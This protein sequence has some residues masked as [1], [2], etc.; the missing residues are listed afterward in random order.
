VALVIR[1]TAPQKG[2]RQFQALTVEGVRR[3]TLGLAKDAKILTC[4]DL[5]P[6]IR[7]SAIP[8]LMERT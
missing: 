4:K 7:A 1:G 2:D 6:I 3:L 5:G 8:A